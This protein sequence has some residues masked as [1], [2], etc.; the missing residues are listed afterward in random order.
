M[1]SL[2]PRIAETH[3]NN[4]S[5]PSIVTW[6]LPTDPANPINWPSLLRWSIITLVSTITFMTG[7]PSSMF[8][9]GVPALMTEFHTTNTY[10]GSFVVTIFVLG[11]GTGPLIFAP[12]SEIYGRLPIQ[13]VGNVG[14]L[15]FTIACAESKT[16]GTLIGMRLLQGIFAAVPLTNG[17]AVIADMV[18]QEERG[19]AL[20]MF[21]MGILLG[22]IVGP[23]CGGFLSAAKGWRWVFWVIAIMVRSFYSIFSTAFS[24]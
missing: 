23:V 21:T 15:M 12:L 7:L 5:D 2:N 9:P 14:F 8:A 6:D 4:E 13:H 22:P 16:L 10:L 11:L 1:P 3:T 20:S 24:C 19:F 18:K 17:G